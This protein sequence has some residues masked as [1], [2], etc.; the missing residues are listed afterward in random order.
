MKVFCSHNKG[1]YLTN[2]GD[3]L[4]PEI[5][6]HFKIKYEVVANPRLADILCIGSVI[7]WC[8]FKDGLTILGS[9]SMWN[10][11]KLNPKSN[12]KF[13][14]GPLT[15]NNIM[16]SGGTCPE[17]YGDPA[18]LLPLFCSESKKE[19]DVGIIPHYVDYVEMKNEFPNFNVI[20][21]LNEDPL[22]VAKEITKCRAIISSSLHGII[23]AHAY[24]IPAAWL[25]YSN[26]LDGDGVKFKDHFYS[27]GL[28]T[29]MATKINEVKFSIGT[30]PD[31]DK[32][33]NEFLKLKK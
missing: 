31:L 2:F 25:K 15:R 8:N 27:M 33:S 10:G 17:I 6:K 7:R 11:E 22:V 30:L 21:I 4:S 1:K 20:P 14:R 24:G 32:I 12:F 16:L 19:H 28:K 26:K 18:L 29:H 13:V 3:A 23:A 5:F 9:G